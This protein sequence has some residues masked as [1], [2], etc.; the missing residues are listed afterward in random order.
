MYS[1]SYFKLR[2]I[3]LTYQFPKKAFDNV[4][5][6]KGASV[7]AVGQNVLLFAKDFRFSDPDGGTEDLADP[8]V[9]YLGFNV[10]L[11]F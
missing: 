7:S 4:R 10:K 9:R 5:F 8:A 11:T 3:S 6:L 2:E 1:L